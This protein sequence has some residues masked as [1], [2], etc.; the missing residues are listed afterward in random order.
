MP[1]VLVSTAHKLVLPP[2]IELALPE[3]FSAI[4]SYLPSF[5]YAQQYMYT[6]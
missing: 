2:P 1:R 4:R 3:Q 5:L 6:T